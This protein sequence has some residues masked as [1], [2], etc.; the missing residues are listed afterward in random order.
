MLVV[1]ILLT[2]TYKRI[3]AV[4]VRMP[5]HFSDEAK[6]LVRSLLKYTPSERLP[7]SRVLRH[8]WIS[9]YDPGAYARACKFI[10]KYI[11]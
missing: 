5:A 1:R 3:A 4:D 2:V 11:N 7:L 8:P 9:R 10:G 6:D